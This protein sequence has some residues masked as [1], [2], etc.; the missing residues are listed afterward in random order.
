MLIDL[1]HVVVAFG[2]ELCVV[3]VLLMHFDHPMHNWDVAA[4]DLEHRDV[5]CPNWVIHVVSEHQQVAAVKSRFH[6][7][8]EDYHDRALRA[9]DYH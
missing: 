2:Q 7:A 8:G 6:G 3:L 1:N 4:L 9:G 5:P